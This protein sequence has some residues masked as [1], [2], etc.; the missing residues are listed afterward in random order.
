MIEIHLLLADRAKDE[1][2]AKSG[3]SS[4]RKNSLYMKKRSC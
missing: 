1:K 3:T 2:E 4:N